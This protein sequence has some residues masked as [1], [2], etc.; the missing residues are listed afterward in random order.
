[1]IRSLNSL[2]SVNPGVRAD[3]VLT[4]RVALPY[5]GYNTAG[6]IRG[7]YKMLSERLLQIP[8]VR[9]ASISSDL[10]LDA[11]GERRAVTPERT[12]DAGGTPP[13]MAVTWVHG[14]YFET[15]GIPIVRGRSFSP[16]EQD[17]D[18]P[19]AIVSRALAARFWPGEDSIGKRIK[20]GISSSTAPLALHRR[21]RRRCR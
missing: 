1:L 17:Q 18:R 19:V 11:D 9:V 8:G 2:L 20:W 14:R 21:H 10:P 15:F 4:M 13:S 3:N 6:R 16:E 5:E 7:F 12:G